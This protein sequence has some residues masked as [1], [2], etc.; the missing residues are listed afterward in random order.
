MNDL[1]Y[2]SERENNREFSDSSFLPSLD[3]LKIEDCPN[4]KGWWQRQRDSV[5]ELHNHSLQ[6]LECPILS[7]R[8]ERGA[9]EDWNKIAHLD[10]RY[11]SESLFYPSP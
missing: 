4:L 7:K 2:I 8:C 3:Q 5:E 1:E 6:I 11:L 9:G 10:I